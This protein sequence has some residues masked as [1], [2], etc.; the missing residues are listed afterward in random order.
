[1]KHKHTVGKLRRI[2]IDELH[3]AIAAEYFKKGPIEPQP[4]DPGCQWADDTD[5][6]DLS[7][8][9]P[10]ATDASGKSELALV[11]DS[12]FFRK[13]RT[14]LMVSGDVTVKITGL[15][16]LIESLARLEQKI[17]ELSE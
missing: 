17:D 6:E 10:K 8:D 4:P 11:V 14:D 12:A 2:I 5:L 9:D 13:Y 16:S 7:D 1:M 3:A 15:E